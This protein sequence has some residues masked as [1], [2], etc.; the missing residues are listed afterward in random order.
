MATGDHVKRTVVQNPVLVSHTV[1]VRVKMRVFDTV[2]AS[3]TAVPGTPVA[4]RAAVF[5][6]NVDVMAVEPAMELIALADI[7]LEQAELVTLVA[8]VGVG[9]LIARVDASTDVDSAVPPSVEVRTLTV[10]VLTEVAVVDAVIALVRERTG[11]GVLAER[12]AEPLVLVDLAFRA[13][14]VLIAEADAVGRQTRV[15]DTGD[16]LRVAEAGAALR[17]AIADILITGC[18]A[19]PS[20][21]AALPGVVHKRIG[22]ARGTVVLRRT[23]TPAQ[24]NRVALSHKLIALLSRPPF[25]AH[26]VPILIKRRIGLTVKTVC[27]A[28]PHTTLTDRVAVV[29]VEHHATVLGDPGWV[30][31]AVPLCITC[32]VKHT[33]DTVPRRRSHTLVAL[34]I[35]VVHLLLARLPAVRKTADTLAALIPLSVCDTMHTV[36]GCRA[37]TFDTGWMA[38]VGHDL[39]AV[40]GPRE[41]A[42]TLPLCCHLC[43]GD[44]EQTGAG[45]ER[46]S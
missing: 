39:A 11:A 5:K 14:P 1:P 44:T 19:P 13:D 8:G 25:L 35:A 34:R 6:L 26:T 22:D 37:G 17:R 21:A 4:N 41:L 20:Q 46:V 33:V 45:L 12:T 2:V 16:A 23:Q 30:A 38:D 40:A 42:Y 15:F 7:V 31:T 27:R 3:V 36:G 28:I 24:T 18:A 29:L 9:A 43:T 32:G 10:P